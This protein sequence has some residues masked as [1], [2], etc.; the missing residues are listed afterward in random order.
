MPKRRAVPYSEGLE[1][2][3]VE[4]VGRDGNTVVEEHEHEADPSPEQH[5]AQL[6][7][8]VQEL[9]HPAA[10]RLQRKQRR[11]SRVRLTKDRTTALR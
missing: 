10:H 8:A 5:P 9:C 11:I 4:A 2:Q 1:E 7:G 3:Q 6:A